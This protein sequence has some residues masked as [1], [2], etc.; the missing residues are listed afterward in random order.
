MQHTPS[1]CELDCYGYYGSARFF[2]FGERLFT[3]SG[4]LMKE[5]RFDRAEL[6]ETGALRLR[7]N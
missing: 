7:E 1:G 6:R 5:L 2:A 4:E 3:L